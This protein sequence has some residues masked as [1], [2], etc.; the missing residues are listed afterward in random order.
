MAL[1]L[2]GI[3]RGI[4]DCQT[5]S[6]EARMPLIHHVVTGSGRPPIVFV[7][8]FACAH[9]DW[10]AQ[11]PRLPPRHQIVAVDLHG[12]GKNAGTT[13]ECP[14]ERYGADVAE[15]VQ[16]LGLPPAIPAGHSMGCRGVNG[17]L[18]MPPV[19]NGRA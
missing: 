1:P 12:H 17:A 15:V 8:G 9:T 18:S 11:E 19:L 16:A 13:S 7:H 14:I 5:I 10:N 6:M 4:A 3:V 2:A